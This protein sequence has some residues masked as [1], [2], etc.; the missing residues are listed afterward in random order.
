MRLLLDTHAFLWFALG[1][2]RIS[3][4]AL[5]ANH[6]RNN[7]KLVSPAT[8]WEIAIKISVGKYRLAEPYDTF[9]QRAIAGNG[10][11]VLAIELQH[12]FLVTTLHFHHRDP[13]DRLLIAQALAENIPLISGDPALD[14]YGIQRVWQ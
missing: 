3:S 6:D 2:S 13:F 5:A 14:A 10:F 1:D 9:M 11:R 8:Y 12:T 4:T 7:Q